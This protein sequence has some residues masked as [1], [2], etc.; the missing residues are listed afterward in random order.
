M[1][2]D[3]PIYRAYVMCVTV[4]LCLYSNVLANQ[5]FVNFT[6]VNVLTWG[7]G[8]NTEEGVGVS[9]ILRENTYPFLA[10]IVLKQSRMVVCERVEG[11]LGR[12]ELMQQLERAIRDNEGE[13][14]VERNER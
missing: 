11:S 14:V 12:M 2:T 8:I 1:P 5:E 13:L 7:V 9:Y 3:S 6:A 10:L 4:V